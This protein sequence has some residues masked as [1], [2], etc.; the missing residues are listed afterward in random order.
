MAFAQSV[1]FQ[2]PPSQL[3]ID[4]KPTFFTDD[5]ETNEESYM[6]STMISPVTH[7]EDR[8]DS[9]GNATQPVFSPQSEWNDFSSAT[10][11]MQ[12]RPF[13]STNP[14]L[15]HQ[16]NNPFLRQ[17]NGPFA[18]QHNPQWPA[19][20]HSQESR[21]PIVPATYEAFNPEFDQQQAQGFPHT[22]PFGP[23]P[24]NVRPSSVFPP[25]STPVPMSASPPPGGKDWMGMA[26]QN[27]PDSRLPKRLRGQSPARYPGNYRSG[28]GIRK[29]NARFEIPHERNLSNIDRL[30]EEAKD[31]DEAKELKQQKR[32]LRN[33]QAAY[34]PTLLLDDFGWRGPPS[35]LSF[36][37]LV[38]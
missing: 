3:S 25:T 34:A 38:N 26:E 11:I 31:D 1:D 5:Y 30:I 19:Y 15:D 17:D 27:H 7:P 24:S 32:L 35:P 18:A 36:G 16:S 37:V 2:R 14:F 9:F 22:G 13:A 4:R 29:K 12:E 10:P 8:R 21:G 28:D 23:M 6:E 20:D 33:R